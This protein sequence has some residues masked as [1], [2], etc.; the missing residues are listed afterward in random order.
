MMSVVC[1]L[2]EAFNNCFC[3]LIDYSGFFR[4]LIRKCIFLKC[5]HEFLKLL[6]VNEEAPFL[7]PILCM[8]PDLTQPLEYFPWIFHKRHMS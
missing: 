8:G 1:C 6:W 3:G 5:H 4:S 2:K 7:V